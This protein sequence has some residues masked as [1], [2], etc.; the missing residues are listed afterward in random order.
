M[1]EGEGGVT[2]G[3][4]VTWGREKRVRG[5]SEEKREGGVSGSERGRDDGEE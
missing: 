1:G 3:K 2:R 4:S 5:R